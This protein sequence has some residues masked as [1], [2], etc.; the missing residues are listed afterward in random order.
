MHNTVVR[1]TRHFTDIKISSPT[2]RKLVKTVCERFGGAG[3]PD[4]RYEVAIALVDNKQ[5]RR[6]NAR[7]LNRSGVTDCL[8]FDL[9]ENNRGRKQPKNRGSEPTRTFEIV[10][11]GEMAL[12]QAEL[13]CHCPRAE[14]AL[15]IAHGLLHQFGF[16]DSDRVKAEKMH[17][18][19]D[20]ILHQL[21]FGTVY[22]NSI[23]RRDRKG[24]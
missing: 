22:K 6:L 1:I 12:E 18:T 10:V 16:D 17:D 15:Y 7:F 3:E 4:I 19:E 5:M 11:N 8:S 9:T 20:R 24:L 14:L 23:K 21:G 13:R 2:I